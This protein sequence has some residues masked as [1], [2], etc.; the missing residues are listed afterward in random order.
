MVIRG[1]THDNMIVYVHVEYF[2]WF[3]IIIFQKINYLILLET[4]AEKKMFLRRESERSLIFYFS[5][6]FAMR[7]ICQYAIKVD[8]KTFV[9]YFPSTRYNL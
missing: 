3:L 8:R 1:S 5:G 9:Q 4:T 6:S 2:W 7:R